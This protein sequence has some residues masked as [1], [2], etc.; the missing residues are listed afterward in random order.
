[1]V[2][3]E[4]PAVEVPR[5]ET[6]WEQRRQSKYIFF[7]EGGDRGAEGAGGGVWGHPWLPRNFFLI[8][9]LKMAICGAFLVQFFC[10]SAKTLRGRK[11]TPAQVYFYW[12][13]IARLALSRDRRHWLG[14]TSGVTTAIGARGRSSEVRSGESGA[15]G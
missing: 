14:R 5:Q 15:G 1:V 12:G 2:E 3:G 11:D 9:D 7:G 13:A 8:L 4:K 10:S 6:G